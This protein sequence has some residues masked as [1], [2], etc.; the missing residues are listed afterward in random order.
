[1]GIPSY[2]SYIIKNHS[3]IIKN[4][5]Y[6]LIDNHIDNLYFDSN[7][8]IYD[9]LRELVTLNYIHN[10]NKFENELIKMVCEKLVSYINIIKPTKN[11]IIAFDGVAPVAKMEQQRTRRF[12]TNFEKKIMKHIN[13]TTEHFWDKT[14][15]TPGTNFMKKLNKQVKSFFNKYKVNV[16]NIIISGS[17]QPGEG[18][19]K[20]FDYIKN[21]KIKHYSSS[22]IIYGLDAD[23][24]MLAIN[25][26]PIS[27]KIYLFR[28]TPEFIKSIDKTLDPN[29]IYI[30]DIPELSFHITQE[31]NSIDKFNIPT[32]KKN[33]RIHDYIFICFMLGNDFLPHFPALNIRTNGI[34]YILNAY[35]NTIGKTNNFLTNGNN[36]NWKHFK[37]FISFLANNEHE[38]IKKEYNIR[39]KK[40]NRNI[41]SDDLKYKY[42]LTP[43]YNRS[44]ELYINPYE[45]FWEKRYYKVLFDIEPTF[46]NIKDICINYLEGLEWTIKYYTIGCPDWHWKYNY[47]YP[48]LLSDL[49]KFIPVFN[50]QMIPDNNNKPIHPYEQLV[51]VLPKDSIHLL[52]KKI[53][54]LVNIYLSHNYPLNPQLQWE[55]CTYIW[56]SHV[57]LPHISI[58]D[59]KEVLTM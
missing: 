11:I 42:L 59:I 52:P 48:P 32:F 7:S 4:Y 47:N 40:Q 25:H 13:P 58:S 54:N 35:K 56:E 5:N 27:K 41:S 39:Q 17:D 28:E 18:E 34:T 12:K 29:E 53:Y 24:I 19:H 2:F 1:M 26:L 50:S 10:S 36:I 14:C 15:I 43:I 57:K 6:F 16:A 8:I 37:T 45:K 20:L 33:I 22:T 44:K 31:M 51:Y 38:Y 49:L 23:L 3:Q 55:F 46:E 21:N 9:C 30:M